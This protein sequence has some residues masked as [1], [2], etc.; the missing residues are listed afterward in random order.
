MFY[1]RNGSAQGDKSDCINGIF[2]VDE[3]S[4]M[5][6]NIANDSGTNANQSDRRYEARITFSNTCQSPKSILRSRKYFLRFFFHSLNFSYRKKKNLLHIFL[7]TTTV[8]AI[9]IRKIFLMNQLYFFFS[10]LYVKMYRNVQYT[11]K[12]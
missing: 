12:M 5:S 6:R 9:S 2:Q 3:A 10:I 1:T 7:V 4:K 11:F 8:I